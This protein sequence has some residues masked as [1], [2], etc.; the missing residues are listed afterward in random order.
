MCYIIATVF[1]NDYHSHCQ[2]A[3]AFAGAPSPAGGNFKPL[4]SA[5]L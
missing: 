5:F 4:L 2:L 3:G 1:E